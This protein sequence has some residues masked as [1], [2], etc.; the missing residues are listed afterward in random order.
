MTVKHR[1]K[2]IIFLLTMIL[3]SLSWS[4]WIKNTVGTK[5][6]FFDV[7]VGD[8][9]NDGVLRVYCSCIDAHLIEWTYNNITNS[10]D[11]V[12]CGAI[13]SGGNDIMMSLWIGTGRGDGVNRIYS[14]SGNGNV[15]EFTCSDSGWELNDLGTPDVVYL[16]ITVARARNDARDR[17][18]AGS[19]ESPVHEYTWSG[20]S[21]SK[22]N[23]SFETRRIWPLAV[24]RGRNDGIER[25]YCPDWAES[26]LREYTWN[27]SGYD[28]V[29]IST[30]NN[31]CKAVVGPGRNDG[32]NHV[33]AAGLLGH[34]YEFSY[35]SKGW[36][37]L[38]IHPGA[39]DLSRYGLC[40]GRTRADGKNRL[41]SG[42]NNGD[43]CEHSW[44]GNSWSDSAIDAV[45]GATAYLTV[46]AGRDDDTMRIYAT[47]IDNQLYE[48]TNTTP[49]VYDPAFIQSKPVARANN[50][51]LVFS[52]SS[53]RYTIPMDGYVKLAL[54]DL[55]GKEL[56]C[57]KEGFQPAGTYTITISREKN[58][59]YRLPTGIYICRLHFNS[60]QEYCKIITMK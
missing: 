40:I 13:P 52:G 29:V 22:F 21:W 12:D 58:S 3:I 8:G 39:A 42:S 17:I 14:T 45:T 19:Y 25:V 47:N 9:R 32:S 36:D 38:D 2:Y 54:Y 28:E 49:F 15:Y 27:G 23:I 16:G 34:I 4:G 53:I 41:Y 43:I 60:S 7:K 59:E 5:S 30:S 56:C 24:G 51:N 55:S 35:N 50:T 33:Y 1:K 57:L 11:M 31:L 44:D 6:N 18:Y 10:W 20:S 46:G 37:T 26:C 48:F